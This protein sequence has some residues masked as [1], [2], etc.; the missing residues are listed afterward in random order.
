MSTS[1]A[2]VVHAPPP[3]PSEGN[4]PCGIPGGVFAAAG[5]RITCQRCNEIISHYRNL[6]HGAGV[7][8]MFRRN[9]GR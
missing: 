8:E 2:H 3:P 1:S 4:P 5:D 9:V 6:F 7:A